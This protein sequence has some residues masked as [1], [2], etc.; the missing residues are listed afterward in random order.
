[1]DK[2]EVSLLGT[3]C[4]VPGAIKWSLRREI[5]RTQR[6][7]LYEMG[8]RSKHSTC[9]SGFIEFSLFAFRIYTCKCV[10][11]RIYRNFAFSYI[12]Y[13]LLTMSQ[14][15]CVEASIQIKCL[16]LL[17]RLSGLVHN[18]SSSL[19][20]V[21]SNLNNFSFPFRLIVKIWIV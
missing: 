1:M 18:K 8:N 10:F 14:D 9:P 13:P 7:S 2:V 12:R 21:A 19:N 20:F 17:F 15:L 6:K 4:S 5:L 16:Y 3:G 11:R